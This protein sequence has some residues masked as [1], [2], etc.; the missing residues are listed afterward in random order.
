M[1]VEKVGLSMGSKVSMKACPQAGRKC[2]KC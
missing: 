1:R 2:P